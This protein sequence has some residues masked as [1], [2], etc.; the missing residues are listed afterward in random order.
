MTINSPHLLIAGSSNMLENIGKTTAYHTKANVAI[1]GDIILYNTEED[2][3]F[4]SYLLNTYK[5]RKQIVKLSQGSTIR[6]V[7]PS[8][9]E[10]YEIRIPSSVNEQETITQLFLDIDLEINGLERKRDKYISIKNGMMQKLLTGE[11]RL[12]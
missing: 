9:F 7:Y 12:K 6:H 4:L 8:T 10:N 1:G 2:V 3:C 5:H 11:I